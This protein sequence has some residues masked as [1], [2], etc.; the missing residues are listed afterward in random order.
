MNQDHRDKGRP[1]SPLLSR[2]ILTAEE[3]NRSILAA[4]DFTRFYDISPSYAR[5][6][7]VELVRAGW[8]TRVG[9]GKYQLM[10]ARTGLEPYPLGDKLTVA[11]QFAPEGFIAYGSAAEY[12]GLTTQVFH[13]V[14]LATPLHRRS[15]TVGNWRVHFVRIP[16]HN[17]EGFQT[18]RRGPNVRVATI[19]RTLIDAVDRPEL[20]GGI[21]DVPEIWRRGRSQAT[22]GQMLDLLPAYRSK[23]LAQRVGYMLDAFGFTLSAQQRAR[24]HEWSDRNKAY[25]FSRRQAGPNESQ[26]YSR[27]WRL[28]IN[29]PGFQ[30][31]TKEARS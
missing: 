20:C 15:T 2:I 9:R 31:P 10:P 14:L 12:H 21:S 26:A 18:L 1:L 8:L 19:E 23:S 7:I 27:E 22:V 11:G 4:A 30:P 29:A 6:M 13:A 16:L 17:V 25:L 24:L 3:E 28:V 5:K